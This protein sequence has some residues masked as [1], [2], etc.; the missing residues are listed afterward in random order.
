MPDC[1]ASP[2]LAFFLA[3]YG[4]RT[5]QC[6]SWCD[7][8]LPRYPYLILLQSLLCDKILQCSPKASLLFAIY[9]PWAGSKAFIFCA[10]C[11]GHSSWPT[12]L[13]AFVK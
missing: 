2:C 3:P 6:W 4:H 12:G 13:R 7:P 10:I 9:T 5:E 11:A 1:I 8:G